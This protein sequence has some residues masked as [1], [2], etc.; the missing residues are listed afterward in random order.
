[1]ARKKKT[2]KDVAKELKTKSKELTKTGGIKPYQNEKGHF[3][4]GNTASTGI[5]K[6]HQKGVVE[7][8]MKKTK[9]L[10][11][12]IDMAYN[13]LLDPE[14]AKSDKIRLIEILLNRGIGKPVQMT[15]ID[16]DQQLPTLIFNFK[17]ETKVT[18]EENDWQEAD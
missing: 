8:I 2:V 14:T 17:G 4:P 5:Y 16:S 6:K 15:Q 18:K 13:M 11:D 9:D 12:V 7:Y 10:T 3:L 1:M